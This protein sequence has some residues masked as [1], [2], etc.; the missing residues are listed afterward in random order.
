MSGDDETARRA[1]PPEPASFVAFCVLARPR[2]CSVL[3]SVA[4]NDA[5]VEDVVQEA[6]ILARHRW[7][8]I[9]WYDRPDAWL[10]KVALR[11]LRRWQRTDDR[12]RPL[13]EVDDPPDDAAVLAFERV[14]RT[15]DLA[16][17]LTTLPPVRRA[18]V[19]L[20]YRLDLS[21]AEIAEALDL[22]SG[23]VK[24]HLYHGRRQLAAVWAPD[25]EGS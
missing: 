21:V 1:G 19:N 9:G 3:R 12:C 7:S 13:G 8:D 18:V 24:S 14:E 5:R 17:A 11:L 15:A 2:V 16:V 22:P 20:H 4:G 6:L 25:E 23:T 10:V